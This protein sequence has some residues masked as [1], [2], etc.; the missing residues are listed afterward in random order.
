VI[1]EEIDEFTDLAPQPI[2]TT[3]QEFN[4]HLVKSKKTITDLSKDEIKSY[5][6]EISTLVG[7]LETLK[8]TLDFKDLCIENKQKTI[9]DQIEERI[10]RAIPNVRFD[11]EHNTLY[12]FLGLQTADQGVKSSVEDLK[13]RFNQRIKKE[14]DSSKIGEIRQLSYL[15]FN[16][17]AKN[18]YDSYIKNESLEKYAI[19]N[20]TTKQI[21]SIIE[22]VLQYK[23]ELDSIKKQFNSA[24]TNVNKLQ[25][26][27]VL[28]QQGDVLSLKK[29]ISSIYLNPHRATLQKA[30]E[31]YQDIATKTRKTVERTVE[32]QLDQIDVDDT[33]VSR[34]INDIQNKCSELDVVGINNTPQPPQNVE[35]NFVLIPSDKDKI[36]ASNIHLQPID[37]KLIKKVKNMEHGSLAEIDTTIKK[38]ETTLSKLRNRKKAIAE[39]CKNSDILQSKIVEYKVM[40]LERIK[41][42]EE[43]KKNLI[44]NLKDK[45]EFEEPLQPL[46]NP[47]HNNESPSS[48]KQEQKNTLSEN[49][50]SDTST[51]TADNNSFYNQSL[52]KSVYE[53]FRR[54]Y[55]QLKKD[56]HKEKLCMPIRPYTLPQQSIKRLIPLVQKKPFTLGRYPGMW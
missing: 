43:C 2:T 44:E 16:P 20:M 50:P 12:H 38:L 52:K 45:K 39:Q 30:H 28:E 33:P 48:D 22:Q 3:T 46:A 25:Q 18:L 40:L 5:D 51:K 14:T 7:K 1:D 11:R 34:L 15:L 17:F 4:T 27:A 13:E 31:A 10:Y 54:S 6:D 23:A 32:A 49:N 55:D 29:K 35:G 56:S 9:V 37:T 41:Y 42:L 19:R 8:D 24:K 26:S 21:S 47:N 36:D 53:Q